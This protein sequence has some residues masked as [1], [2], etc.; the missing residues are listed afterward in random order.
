METVGSNTSTYTW[1]DNWAKIPES[2][3][4]RRNGRTHGIA[5]TQKG[6]IVVFCQANPSV[7]IFSPKG[8]LINAWGS[9]FLGAHAITATVEDD[10]DYLWLVDETSHEI[11]KTTLNGQT[12]MNIVQPNHPIYDRGTAYIPTSV[13]VFEERFGGNGDIWVADG[14]GA[15]LIH[16]YDKHGQWIQ[17]FTG[18]KNNA[19]RLACPHGIA[20]RYD[21]D[22]P[23]IYVADRSNERIVVLDTNGICIKN[24]PDIFHSPCS[25]TFHNGHTYI[26]ELFHRH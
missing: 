17:S 21:R 4:S 22:Q 3:S 18:D 25:I 1:I 26:P 11:A 8:E 5:I 13:A 14:Y 24:I 2:E 20:F 7:H 23:Q 6:N 9:R 10:V 19:G 12:V 15:S 16:R